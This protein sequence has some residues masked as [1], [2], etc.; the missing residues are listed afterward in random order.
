MAT[1]ERRSHGALCMCTSREISQGIESVLYNPDVNPRLRSRLQCIVKSTL[2][3]TRLVPSLNDMLLAD[4]SPAGISRFRM[5]LG[6]PLLG[7]S[8]R[9]DEM[10][11]SSTSSVTATTIASPP[12]KPYGTATRFE[13]IPYEIQNSKNDWSSGMWV[14][15]ATGSTAAM[16]SAGGGIMPAHSNELQY[17]IREHVIEKVPGDEGGWGQRGRGGGD[18]GSGGYDDDDNSRNN[19]GILK[20]N[21]YL[22]GGERLHLRWNSR[23]GRIY[24]D[25]E[26]VS[27]DLVLGDEILISSD[28]PPLPLFGKDDNHLLD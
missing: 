3:E 28:A 7:N 13:G 11:P 10:S 22:R 20:D 24:I 12:Y 21:G 1:D 26:H 9:G 19:K 2:S 5:G 4:K 16:E 17:L 27:H 6:K 14:C 18:G 25:G 23:G 8:S 15:T